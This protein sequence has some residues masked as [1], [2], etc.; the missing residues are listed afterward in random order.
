MNRNIALLGP[1]PDAHEAYCA[2]SIISKFE[3]RGG[4]NRLTFMLS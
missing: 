3:E 4:A 1:K 2:T